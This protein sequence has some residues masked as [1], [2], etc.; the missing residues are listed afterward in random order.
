VTFEGK[1]A[2]AATVRFYRVEADAPNR[3]RYVADGLTDEDGTF[4][5]STYKAFDGIPVGDY[6]VTVV[7]TG[8]YAT[9][10][11]RE[12]NKL[13]AKYAE[14]RTTPLRITVKAGENVVD[15]NLTK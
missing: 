14:E 3:P 11:T 2:A 10:Q 1:P 4:R 15:L 9:N 7:Q 12:E 13:P 5:L 8:R 6:K